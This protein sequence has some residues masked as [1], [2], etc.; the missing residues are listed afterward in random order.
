LW[1]VSDLLSY[2]EFNIRFQFPG[3]KK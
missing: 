2:V 1:E 3:F